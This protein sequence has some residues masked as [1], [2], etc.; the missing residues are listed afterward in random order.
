MNFRKYW[1]ELYLTAMVLTALVIVIGSAILLHD[2]PG[3]GLIAFGV[4]IAV[5]GVGLYD[6]WQDAELAKQRV[7]TRR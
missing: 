5:L 1:H 7:R 2:L 3:L 6:Q 4:F